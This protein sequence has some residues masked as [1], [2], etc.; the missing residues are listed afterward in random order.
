MKGKRKYMRM[1]FHFH[2]GRRY[3]LYGHGCLIPVI[4]TISGI[5]AAAVIFLSLLSFL[6]PSPVD[7]PSLSATQSHDRVSLLVFS[8]LFS[9]SSSSSS[10]TISDSCF[11]FD[12][13]QLKNDRTNPIEGVSFHVPVRILLLLLLVGSIFGSPIVVDV[14]WFRLFRFDLMLVFFCMCFLFG[15]VEWR[16]ECQARSLEFEI[17]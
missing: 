14:W 13:W 12:D 17:V 6:A 16:R 11:V 1:S 3:H 10:F 5:S 9:S 4:S 8:S 2:R 15:R 7:S